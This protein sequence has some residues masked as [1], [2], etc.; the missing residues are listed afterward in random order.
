MIILVALYSTAQY[1]VGT[2]SVDTGLCIVSLILTKIIMMTPNIVSKYQ[3]V[4]VHTQ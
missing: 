2:Y 1:V 4:M 3:D